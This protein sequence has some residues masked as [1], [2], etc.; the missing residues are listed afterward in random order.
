M[1]QW[2]TGSVANAILALVDSVPTAVSGALLLSMIDQKIGYITERTGIVID[3]NS[4]DPKFQ[5][6]LIKLTSCEMLSYME[7][8]GADVSS[9]TLGDFSEKRG[10]DSNIMTA[11]KSLCEQAEKELQAILINSGG[12]CKFYKALG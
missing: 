6:V 12:G 8:I 1:A 10:A 3:S 11:S 9:I 4:I 2:N 5:S 7:T